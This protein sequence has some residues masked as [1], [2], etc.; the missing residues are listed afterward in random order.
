MAEEDEC[1]DDHPGKSPSII[2][3]PYHPWHHRWPSE[4]L[5]MV[6]QCS[7]LND[8]H[9]FKEFLNSEQNQLRSPL[10]LSDSES[11]E[12]VKHM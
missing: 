9:Y 1:V 12:H 5:H 8:P 2:L 7:T 11:T 3:P 4:A 6:P 10:S